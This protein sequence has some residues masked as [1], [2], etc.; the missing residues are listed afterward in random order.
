M[1]CKIFSCYSFEVIIPWKYNYQNFCHGNSNSQLVTL[2]QYE[3]LLC[4]LKVC[5]NKSKP[6][7]SSVSPPLA[8]YF[9]PNWNSFLSNWKNSFWLDLRNLWIFNDKC[10]VLFSSVWFSDF[11]SFRLLFWLWEKIIISIHISPIF[12]HW[13]SFFSGHRLTNCSCQQLFYLPSII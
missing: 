12:C 6:F 3:D 5:K 10:L 8:S 11:F 4:D 13:R 9:M 2:L 1:T 7:F